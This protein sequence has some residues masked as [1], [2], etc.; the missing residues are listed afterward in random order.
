MQQLAEV[1]KILVEQHK[2]ICFS[3]NK[4]RNN[5]YVHTRS[6]LNFKGITLSFICENIIQILN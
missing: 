6:F 3:Q 4:C 1:Q 2:I 5:T